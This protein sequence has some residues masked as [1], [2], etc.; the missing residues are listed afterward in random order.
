[1]PIF[2]LEDKKV[3]FVR[4]PSAGGDHIYDWLDS[5][6]TVSLLQQSAIKSLRVPPQHLPYNDIIA[7]LGNAWDYSFSVVRNPYARI[8]REYFISLTDEQ[9]TDPLTWPDFTRW[10]VLQ[11]SNAHLDCF[12]KGNHFCLQS[13]MVGDDLDIYRLEDGLSILQENLS[14]LA[15]IKGEKIAEYPQ[16][17]YHEHIVWTNDALSAVNRFY[18]ADFERFFYT[19]KKPDYKKV[20]SPL[21]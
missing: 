1:M 3:L 11:L 21:V 10:V 8:E 9:K 4:I 17:S 6:G 14:S 15:N 16:K 5:C 19:M 2:N 18:K 13:S 20:E 7:L 12:Y